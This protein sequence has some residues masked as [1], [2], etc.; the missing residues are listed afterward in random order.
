MLSISFLYFFCRVREVSG[1]AFLSFHGSFLFFCR[2]GYKLPLITQRT[3]S[4]DQFKVFVETGKIIKSTFIAKLLDAEVVFDQQ[5]AGV[6][7][8]KLEKKAGIGLPGPGFEETAEGVG[9]D[10][11]HSRYLFQLDGPFEVR[12]TVF[13]DEVHSFV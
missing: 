5:L 6:S 11:G 3:L 13:I 1:S 7:D 10:I 9:A 12:K 4:G 8:T 2:V